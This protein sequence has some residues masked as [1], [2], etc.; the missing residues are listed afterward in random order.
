MQVGL[1]IL[2]FAK[3]HKFSVSLNPGLQVSHLM[4][5][6]IDTWNSSCW[7]LKNY[8]VGLLGIFYQENGGLLL[9]RDVKGWQAVNNIL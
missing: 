9:S 1:S 5:T 4:R 8:P 2:N 6:A 3:R 7:T